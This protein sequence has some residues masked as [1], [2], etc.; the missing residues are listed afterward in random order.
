MVDPGISGGVATLGK[1][2]DRKLM[3][4]KKKNDREKVRL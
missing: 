1:S 3:K 4:M 2:F